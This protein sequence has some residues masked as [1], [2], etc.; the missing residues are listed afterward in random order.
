MMEKLE[1]FELRMKQVKTMVKLCA[2]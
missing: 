2:S 1:T